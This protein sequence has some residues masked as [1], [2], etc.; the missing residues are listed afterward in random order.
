MQKNIWTKVGF[1]FSISLWC[2][3]TLIRIFHHAPW[4]DEAHAWAIAQDLNIFELFKF[5]KTEGHTFLWY[6]LLMPFAKTNFMYPYSMKL[7]NWVFCFSALLIFWL[8]APFNNW[9]KFFVTFGFP[10]LAVYS[11]L[12]RCYAI[13]ILFLFM[14]ISMDKEK[15]KHPNWYSLLLILLANTSLMGAVPATVLGI[16]FAYEMIKNKQK[17]VVPFSIAIFGAILVL[18]PLVGSIDKGLSIYQTTITL[19]DAIGSHLTLN[20]FYIWTFYSLL[21]LSLMVA[22]WVKNKIFPTFFAFSVLILTGIFCVYSGYL[23]HLFFIY[24]YFICS[25]WLILQKEEDLKWK[26]LITIAIIVISLPALNYHPDEKDLDLVFKNN[27]GHVVEEIKKDKNLENSTIIIVR[28]FDTAI[29]PY[30]YKTGVTLVNYCSADL[31]GHN[32]MDYV[33]SKNCI[34]DLILGSQLISLDNKVFD[35]WYSDNLYMLTLD[36]IKLDE[37]GSEKLNYG[38]SLYKDYGKNYLWKVQKIR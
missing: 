8:K 29:Q 30:F 22:F 10:F 15:L 16:R 25:C 32:T 9:V 37:N 26:N 36:K 4:Y 38:F 17:L 24:I 12:A 21:A 11:L 31:L 2:V 27:V 1:I 23:W 6:V 28:Q 35:K 34:N 13:G 3:I 5:L 19:V 14:L 20:S 18:L 7:L 33:R